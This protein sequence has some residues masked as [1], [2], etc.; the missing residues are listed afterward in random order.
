MFVFL[1]SNVSEKEKKNRNSRSRIFFSFFVFTF[2]FLAGVCIDE[3][4]HFCIFTA[5]KADVFT[6]FQRHAWY[7]VTTYV[8]MLDQCVYREGSSP[9]CHLDTTITD[10]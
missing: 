8:C 10:K 4:T 3:I 1:W 2:L 9:K 5:S 6:V 7:S